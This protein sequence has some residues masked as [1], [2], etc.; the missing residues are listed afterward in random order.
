MRYRLVV[1]A[2]TILVTGCKSTT[3]SFIND[4]L[5]CWS[6]S[7]VETRGRSDELML[8]LNNSKASLEI[9]HTNTHNESQSTT[10]GQSGDISLFITGVY[11][12]KFNVGGCE[13]GRQLNSR[14]FECATRDVNMVCVDANNQH[15]MLF[16]HKD[17]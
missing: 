15:R 7:T 5:T 14:A 16:K 10:C 11:K 2:L 12:I 8:C 6:H 1:F 3:A 9:E 17:V 4:S 13:N